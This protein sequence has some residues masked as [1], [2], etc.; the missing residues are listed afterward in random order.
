MPKTLSVAKRE[1]RGGEARTSALAVRRHLKIGPKGDL[2]AS[3]NF[4]DLAQQAASAYA[5]SLPSARKHMAGLS[6]C[7]VRLTAYW[8]KRWAHTR[9]LRE[10]HPDR[11]SLQDV[12]EN[13]PRARRPARRD[14][15]HRRGAAVRPGRAARAARARQV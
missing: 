9:R 2:I 7:D 3:F 1:K 15:R 5:A 8:H 6:S 11:S 14:S 12:R 10:A 13:K 4:N